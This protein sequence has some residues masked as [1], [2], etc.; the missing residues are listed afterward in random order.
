M[1]TLEITATVSPP[2][3][4]TASIPPDIAPGPHRVVLVIEEQP[5]PP[6]ST[7]PLLGWTTY[8]ATLTVSDA[9]FSREMLYADER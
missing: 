4:L 9:T 8:S 3:V 2:G 7:D 1:R 6:A 5:A